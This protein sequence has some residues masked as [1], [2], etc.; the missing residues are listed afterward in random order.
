MRTNLPPTN[1]KPFA[2]TNLLALCTDCLT[3][4]NLQHIILSDLERGVRKTTQKKELNQYQKPHKIIKTRD[5]CGV[6]SDEYGSVNQVNL[7]NTFM[8]SNSSFQMK[9]FQ[10]QSV[11]KLF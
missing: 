2:A 10:K 11:L 9:F 3:H 6:R 7:K 5:H 4:S 8:K 1:C